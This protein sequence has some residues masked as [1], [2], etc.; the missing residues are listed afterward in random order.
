MYC[1]I[2]SRWAQQNLRVVNIKINIDYYSFL[3]S[4]CCIILYNHLLLSISC[5]FHSVYSEVP[6][7]QQF[8]DCLLNES[9]EKAMAAKE[10]VKRVRQNVI[11]SKQVL[12]VN[13]TDITRY[14][15]KQIE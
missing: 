6:E 4:K 13:P 1:V 5:Q 9:N 12:G 8:I 3:K 14:R 7:A 2:K 10:T 11:D 15:K